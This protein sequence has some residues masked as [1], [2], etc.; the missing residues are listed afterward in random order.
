[1]SRRW[2]EFVA[3][4]GDRVGLGTAGLL[5]LLA[6]ALAGAA[7]YWFP[8]WLPWHWWS[9]LVGFLRAH[10]PGRGD[11]RGRWRPHW[12][13]WRWR[14]WR[15]RAGRLRRRRRRQPQAEPAVPEPG[16]ELPDL[17]AQSFL[18]LADWLAGQGRYAEAVRER[19]RA[20]VRVLVDAGI[21]VNTPGATITELAAAASAA[22]PAVRPALA[23]ASLVFSDIW[24][25]QRPAGQQHDLQ[26][27]GYGRDVDAVLAGQSPVA[28]GPVAGV[29]AR[30]GG[31]P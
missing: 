6:A 16:L 7:W 1:M 24:Y 28:T 9:R 8:G 14:A 29:A 31:R 10:R 4:V 27:R 22:R 25:G 2:T 20:I 18:S 3:A 23:G 30:P 5:L 11:T 21:I 19:L 13:R 17:P 15:W 26:M 12:P